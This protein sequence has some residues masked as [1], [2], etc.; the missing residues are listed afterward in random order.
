MK[1]PASRRASDC[2]A[3]TSAAHECVR[4][5]PMRKLRFRMLLPFLHRIADRHDLSAGEAREAMLAI[6]SGDA[7]TPQIA[8]FLVALRMK[9]ET[10]DELLGFARAMR[11]KSTRVEHGLNGENVLDTCGTGG[12]GPSTF[13]ISTVVAFVV[14][15]AGV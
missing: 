13:N 1:P 14:A 15:G 2:G 8:A 12:E 9:G 3:R 4:C 5:G 7:S 11:E 10:A 6:L